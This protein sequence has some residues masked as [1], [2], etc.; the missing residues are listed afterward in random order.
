[1]FDLVCLPG[2]GGAMKPASR[3]GIG[4]SA[5]NVLETSLDNS[6]PE[7]TNSHLKRGDVTRT[8]GPRSA[9]RQFRSLL[10]LSTNKKHSGSSDNLDFDIESFQTVDVST[11][12]FRD[13]FAALNEFRLRGDM[14][15]LELKIGSRSFLCHRVV[16]SCC[17]RYFRS[18]FT[19]QMRESRSHSV[20]LKELDSQAV[21][22]LLQ[23]AYSGRVTVTIDNVQPLLYA[24]SFLQF[25]HVAQACGDFMKQQLHPTNCI[26]MR[27]FAEQHG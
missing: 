16:L 8:P 10:N 25:E 2:G 3:N 9:Q 23:F 7:P 19:S 24:A 20:E 18:M 22:C 17:S 15:D 6:P 11:E 1:M 26:E 21:D 5:G 12:M 13:N 27:R 14:C 4:G